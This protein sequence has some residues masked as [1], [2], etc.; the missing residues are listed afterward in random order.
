[1]EEHFHAI[2]NHGILSEPKPYPLPAV[3]EFLNSPD[4]EV[5]EFDLFNEIE[6]WYNK[7]KHVLSA[8]NIKSVFSLIRYPLIAKE[9]L[10]DTVHPTNLADPDLYKAV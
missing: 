1:M 9:C 8:D 2:V 7:Q 3:I 6:Q 10:I 4:L 5:S